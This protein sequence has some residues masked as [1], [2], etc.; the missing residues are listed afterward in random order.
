MRLPDWRSVLAAY[1]A[2]V[3]AAGSFVPEQVNA[4]QQAA[5]SQTGADTSAAGENNGQ[6]LTRPEDLFQLRYL[7]QTAPGSGGTSA[8]VRTVTTDSEI[9]R[10]DKEFDLGPQWKWALRGDLPFI[11]KNPISDDNPAGDFLHGVGDADVQATVIYQFDAR[12]A[13]GAGVRIVAPTGEDNL[14]SGKWTAQPVVGARYS[15]PELSDGSY[16]EPVVRYAV[17]FAG[18]PTKKDISNLQFAPMMNVA[19][20]DHWFLTMYPTPDIRLNYGDPVAGQTGRLFL[21]LDFMVGRSIAK[22]VTISAEFGIPIIRDYPV[23]DFKTIV[24]FNMKF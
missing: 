8:L 24:R 19:L 1:L 17:S 12:W 15:L 23:Y 5:S 9:L 7:Y 22:G 2:G 10:V 14:T 21:P 18:D 13:A 4:Q 20:P 11:E 16:F 6:D 3:A